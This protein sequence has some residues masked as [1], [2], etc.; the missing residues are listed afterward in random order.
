[1]PDLSSSGSVGGMSR[2]RQ[3]AAISEATSV[4]GKAA[5]DDGSTDADARL[6]SSVS[7]EGNAGFRVGSTNLSPYAG[8]ARRSAFAPAICRERVLAGMAN[9]EPVD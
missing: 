4:V 1:M 7:P 6:E 5:R 2:A 9:V 3:L 8:Y